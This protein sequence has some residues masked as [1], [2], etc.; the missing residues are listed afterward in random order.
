LAAPVQAAGELPGAFV[1]VAST[2]SFLPEASALHGDELVWA[3]RAQDGGVDIL[4]TNVSTHETTLLTSIAPSGGGLRLQGI[5]FD[6]RW[7][8]WLDD[9]FGNVEAF[10]M[11]TS[12]GSLRRLTST[13][14]HESGITASDGR[15]AWEL[16][17]KVQVAE[18]ETNAR[19]SPSLAG[20]IDG[21]PCLSGPFLSWSRADSEGN[22]SL[23]AL[24]LASNQ[25]HVV[26]SQASF[27]QG[28]AHCDGMQVAWE[29]TQYYDPVTGKRKSVRMVRWADLADD[30]SHNVTL[31][32]Q[33]HGRLLGFAAGHLTWLDLASE[34][35][36][37]HSHDVAANVTTEL[38]QVEF[39]GISRQAIVVAREAP[40]GQWTLYAKR[41]D[42]EEPSPKGIPGPAVTALA[43]GLLLAAAVRSRPRH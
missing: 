40:A 8:S 34:G 6:G 15:A 35:L 4:R 12:K 13:Q 18:M 10:A 43:I 1:R 22:S 36:V 39:A 14:Q 20:S 30:S 32:D 26:A 29:S 33:R 37:V 25:T 42:A 7:V 2:A 9:R 21:E 23:V 38:V 28:N 5:A 11:D 41:W 19:W 17:G 3:S 31:I 27:G 24:E 16:E